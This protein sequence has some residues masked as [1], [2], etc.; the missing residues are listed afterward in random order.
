MSQQTW[1]GFSESYIPSVQLFKESVYQETH[2]MLANIPDVVPWKEQPHLFY[3]YLIICPSIRRTACLNSEIIFFFLCFVIAFHILEKNS[4]PATGTNQLSLKPFVLEGHT[5]A[6][7]VQ[8]VIDTLL[9]LGFVNCL[10]IALA[11]CMSQIPQVM[12]NPCSRWK[13]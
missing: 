11:V 7:N 10:L 3:L 2:F 12:F 1:K 9:W 6:D 8:S 5:K 4:I 13:R